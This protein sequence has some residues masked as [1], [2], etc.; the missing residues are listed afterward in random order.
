LAEERKILIIDDDPMT[1]KILTTFLNQEY[2]LRIANSAAQAMTLM[3]KFTPDLILLDIE[4]PDITGFEFLH[5]I[6]KNP[7]FMSTP[8]VIVSG[9]SEAEFVAH[10]ENT[11][12]S[13]LVAKPIDR[14]D[15]TAKIKFAFEHPKKN[16]W[17]I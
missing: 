4:M 16:V 8:V 11:G 12:A 10:A 13:C 17:G 14:D 1:L 5:T 3:A 15:L 7:R 2:E 9:H 6:K